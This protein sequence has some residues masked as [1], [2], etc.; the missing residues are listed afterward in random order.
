MRKNAGSLPVKAVM[1]GPTVL[2][3]LIF[4]LA[5]L[6]IVVGISLSLIHI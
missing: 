4:L 3:L 2:W 1:I 5:P 6:F